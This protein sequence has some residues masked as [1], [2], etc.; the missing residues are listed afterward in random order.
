MARQPRGGGIGGAGD[1]QHP[2][3]VPLLAG[4][5]QFGLEPGRNETTVMPPMKA[6]AIFIPSGR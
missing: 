1:S 6:A 5:L 3:A 4:D 2:I